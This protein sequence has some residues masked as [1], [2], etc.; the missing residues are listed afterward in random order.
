[1]KLGLLNAAALIVALSGSMLLT[2]KGGQAL[3]GEH[4]VR[5][6]EVLV[7]ASGTRVAT[8]HY[9][10]ILSASTVAD[11]ILVE[12]CETN[13][14]AGYTRFGRSSPAAHRFAGK[15]VVDRIDD[16]EAVLALSP[17]LV[18]VNGLGDPRKIARLREAGLTVFDLG[19]MKG[20]ATFLE[21]IRTVGTLIGAPER[22]ERFAQSFEARMRQAAADVPVAERRGAM[23]VGAIGNQLY[24]GASGTSYHD[25]LVHAGL[26]DV[27]AERFDGW[28]VYSA[29]DILALDP[30]LVVTEDGHGQIFC[31][32]PGLASLAACR[33]P[34]RI[35]ELPDA[36]ASDAGAGMLAATEALRRAVYGAPEPPP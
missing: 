22:G 31:R 11:G 36:I 32:Y 7:D 19:H 33:E 17:D 27:A 9:E 18:I 26:R 24:G 15:P 4:V 20:L 8:R 16:L 10:R 13:R 35:V 23:W 34:D 3:G 25:V 1:M 6:A 28:P 29:E 5:A 21:D 12:L 30:E 14:I 2:A